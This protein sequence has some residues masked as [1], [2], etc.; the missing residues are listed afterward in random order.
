[1]CRLLDTALNMALCDHG[2]CCHTLRCSTAPK[3][4][5]ETT[6][7]PH[8]DSQPA[9]PG[10]LRACPPPPASRLTLFPRVKLQM[11]RIFP[12]ER[13]QDSG[14]VKLGSVDNEQAHA[15]AQAPQAQAS[16]QYAYH[17]GFLSSECSILQAQFVLHR[18]LLL[19][20]SFCGGLQFSRNLF[21]FT[22]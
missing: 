10:L 17:T 18:L 16:L 19:P 14:Q 7:C 13:A 8:P 9:A 3:Y 12:S 4:Y 1:M 5:S 21:C 6:G 2:A 15:Q 11:P 20:M 22:H